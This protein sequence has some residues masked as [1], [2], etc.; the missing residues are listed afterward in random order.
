[1]LFSHVAYLFLALIYNKVSDITSLAS[2]MDV[3]KTIMITFLIGNKEV[4]K[5]VPSENEKGIEA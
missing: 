5:A 1:M 4:R 2:P 3:L